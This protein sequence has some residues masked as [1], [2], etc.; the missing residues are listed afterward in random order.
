M[1]PY[2]AGQNNVL[3]KPLSHRKQAKVVAATAL[4]AQTSERVLV[5]F[6]NLGFFGRMRWLLTGKVK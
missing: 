3:V 4:V 6:L 5:S 1:N 2:N